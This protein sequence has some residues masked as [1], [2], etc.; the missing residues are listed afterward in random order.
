MNK[1]CQ[2][3]RPYSLGKNDFFQGRSVLGVSGLLMSQ[4]RLCTAA[5]FA[6][7][8]SAEIKVLLRL[9][10]TE[11]LVAARPRPLC[12][13]VGSTKRPFCLGFSAW[14]DQLCSRWGTS[15]LIPLV[16]ICPHLIKFICKLWG[17]NKQQYT[18]ISYQIMYLN[19]YMFFF[20][21]WNAWHINSSPGF[22]HLQMP[23][24]FGKAPD[25]FFSSSK[26]C[27]WNYYFSSYLPTSVPH[28]MN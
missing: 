7:S 25:V 1:P 13:P 27:S 3:K 8:G 10:V 23:P 24:M 9:L 4:V 12:H 2:Y 17:L 19:V 20:L 26:T 16:P 22:L 6:G 11:T 18:P 14:R 21:N 5:G 28:A 15:A